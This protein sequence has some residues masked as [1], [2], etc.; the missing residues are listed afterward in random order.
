MNLHYR[1]AAEHDISSLARLR[2]EFDRED[3]DAPPVVP[4]ARFV[5]A[6]EAFLR[7]GLLQ[8]EWTCWIAE[9]CRRDRGAHLRLPHSF[10][11]PVPAV[12]KIPTDM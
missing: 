8:G 9:S 7:Q 4:Y 6:C 2:W 1:P 11:F 10:R 3:Y 5:E 12:L